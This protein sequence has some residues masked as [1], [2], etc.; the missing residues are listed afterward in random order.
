MS[1]IGIVTGPAWTAMGGTTLSIE[2]T[3][4]HNR[5]RGFKLTGQSGDVM[6]ESAEIAYSH[7]IHTSRN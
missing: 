6:K 7:V 5:S 1:R 4:A 2:G 3:R